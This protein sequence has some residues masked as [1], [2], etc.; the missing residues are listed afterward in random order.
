MEKEKQIPKQIKTELKKAIPRVDLQTE[1]KAVAKK[2]LDLQKEKKLL[3]D[4]TN[5]KITKLNQEIQQCDGAMNM[6]SKFIN[7]KKEVKKV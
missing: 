3:I 1:F 4:T 5:E 7:M 6:L 2:K